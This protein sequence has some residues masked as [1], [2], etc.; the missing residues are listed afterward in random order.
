MFPE[1]GEHC[2][3]VSLFNLLILRTFGREVDTY[4]DVRYNVHIQEGLC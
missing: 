3:D 1:R 2:P 4:L